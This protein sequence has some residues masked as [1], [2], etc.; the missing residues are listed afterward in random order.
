MVCL[1]IK[2]TYPIYNGNA[3]SFTSDGVDDDAVPVSDNFKE[4]RGEDST[5]HSFI[6]RK[7]STVATLGSI[8]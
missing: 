1:H 4:D 5:S 7:L 2:P 8:L 6:S 3:Y